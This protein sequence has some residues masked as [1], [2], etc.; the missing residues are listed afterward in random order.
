[1]VEDHVDHHRDRHYQYDIHQFCQT[2]RGGILH[3]GADDES[4]PANPCANV[5]NEAAQA[6]D[7]CQHNE[8]RQAE[9]PKEND[10]DD[11]RDCHNCEFAADEGVE[12]FADLQAKAAEVFFKTCNANVDHPPADAICFRSD[13]K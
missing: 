9:D 3:N 6:S 7:D 12:Y 8:V 5:R 11:N 13:E 1:M 10:V 4:D 2:I